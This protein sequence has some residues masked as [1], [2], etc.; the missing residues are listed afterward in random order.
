MNLLNTILL[1]LTADQD[2]EELANRAREASERARA[3]EASLN[4]NDALITT[5]M[6]MIPIVIF[7]ALFMIISYKK[8]G[9]RTFL[10]KYIQDYG[11]DSP[12]T[13]GM[14]KSIT[15]KILSREGYNYSELHIGHEVGNR[16]EGSFYTNGNELHDITIITDGWNVNYR[17]D[18]GPTRRFTQ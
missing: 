16:F 5:L 17:I 1:T 10:N 2:L 15:D 18:N 4:S 3:A 12:N 14:L 7:V 13:I 6:I 8:T 11:Y 9:G